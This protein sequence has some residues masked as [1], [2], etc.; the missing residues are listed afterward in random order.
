LRCSGFEH[1]RSLF[2]VAN[3]LVQQVGTGWVDGVMDDAD[4]IDCGVDPRGDWQFL[5][6][7]WGR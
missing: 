2:H 7:A 5:T 6:L 3:D 4:G 1:P